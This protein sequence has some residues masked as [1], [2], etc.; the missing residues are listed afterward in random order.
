MEPIP[1]MPIR[2]SVANPGSNK[3]RGAGKIVVFF[4][5]TNAVLRIRIL[6]LFDP[7]SGIDKKKSGSGSEMNNPDHISES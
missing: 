5:A 4:V 7:G 3:R 6:C 1:M 2:S